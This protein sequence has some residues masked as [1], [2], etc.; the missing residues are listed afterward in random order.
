MTGPATE[1]T[2]AKVPMTMPVKET[3]LP[4]AAE[5]KGAESGV[6]MYLPYRG[7]ENQSG[8]ADKA[9]EADDEGAVGVG[10]RGEEEGWSSRRRW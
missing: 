7:A 6:T 3:A 4:M 5:S 2:P 1:W 10:W 8:G 9:E